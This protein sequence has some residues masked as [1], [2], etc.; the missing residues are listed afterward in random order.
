MEKIKFAV[1]QK[2]FDSGAAD[3]RLVPVEDLTKTEARLMD[4]GDMIAGRG[5]DKW[6][7]GFATQ[8]RARGF[9]NERVKK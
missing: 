8:E 5:F 6:V 4:R 7:D 2:Y 1:I 3:L 9:L